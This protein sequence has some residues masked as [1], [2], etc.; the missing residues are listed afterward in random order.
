MKRFFFI[1]FLFV[2]VIN[3]HAQQVIPLYPG[4]AP[5]SESWTHQEKADTN[6]ATNQVMITNVVNPSLLVYKPAK[7]NGLAMI[8][9]PGG[10][11]RALSL[12]NEGIDVAKYLVSRGITA[13][14]LKYRLVPDQF[15]NIQ[16]AF[17]D[18]QTKNFQRIDSIN[19][20]YVPLAVND[21]LAAIQYAR[22][23]A[24][25]FNIHPNRIGIMG[26]SAGGTLAASTAH[27][28]QAQNRPDFAAPIYA[29]TPAVLGDAVP[30]DA[31]PLFLLFAANDFIADGNPG[32]YQKWKAA[33]KS[34][35]LHAYPDGGHGFGIRK[36]NM[37]T[38]RWEDRLVD[39]MY[40]QFPKQEI[41]TFWKDVD[42]VGDNTIGHKLDIHLPFNTKGPFPVVMAIY[43][44]AWF[45]NNAKGNVYREGL[46]QKLLQAGYAVVSINHRSSRDAKF[47]AQIQDVKAAIR[48]IRAHAAQYQLDTSF[49]GITG[50]SSGGHLSTL[51]GTSNLVTKHKVNKEEMDLEGQL[52][53]SNSF[54]SKVH[55]VVDWF[56]PTD[57]LIVDSCGSVFQHNG[58]WSP[59]SQLLDGAIQEIKDKCALANPITYIHKNNPPF[60][61][62]H[63][64]KDGDVP[65][66][67]SEKLFQRLQAAKVKSELILVPGGGHGPGVMTDLYFDKMVNFFNQV[68]NKPQ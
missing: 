52:G 40:Y 34:A 44:S 23:H 63:G 3:I 30:A 42:Y 22:A 50:W 6:K 61:I 18:I 11:F 57:F 38:D 46:G 2:R 36:Q 25:E 7:P 17:A 16:Q 47:P 9:C 8:I 15:G 56:G 14:V 32:L 4:K 51:A 67:Q 41:G 60:L 12:N 53:T 43:G 5:G 65:P 64:D 19:M 59:E 49:I 58:R 21:G 68:L 27:T 31:P 13:F 48:F 28:Y 54:S 35:E 24:A 62:L 45:S 29:Y 1:G 10:A 39:W 55:A 20:P 33:G 37:S 26:F 66:C